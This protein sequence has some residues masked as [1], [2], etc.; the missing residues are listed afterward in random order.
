MSR[1]PSKRSLLIVLGVCEAGIDAVLCC[2]LRENLVIM[3]R[4][5]DNLRL[6]RGGLGLSGCHD[7]PFVGTPYFSH[8]HCLF[9]WV[10]L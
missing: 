3:Q 5:Q 1:E 8:F 9:S 2:E 4:L 7:E 6:E 10:Y